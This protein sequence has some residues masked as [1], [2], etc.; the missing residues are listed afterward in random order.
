ME[1]KYLIDTNI[2]IYYLDDKITEKIR[3]R[4]EKFLDGATIFY[5]NERRPV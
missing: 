5:V 4:I 3:E 2:L 1:E